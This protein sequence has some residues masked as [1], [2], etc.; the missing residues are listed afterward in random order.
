MKGAIL[1][2]LLVYGIPLWKLRY[3]RRSAA[4]KSPLEV[5]A[6]GSAGA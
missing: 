6:L 3:R 5:P 2:A 4:T 1:V